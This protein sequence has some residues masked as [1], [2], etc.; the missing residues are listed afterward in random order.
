MG[1]TTMEEMLRRVEGNGRER[2][3]ATAECMWELATQRWTEAE[4]ILN[5]QKLWPHG[6]PKGQA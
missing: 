1:A 2:G 5:T 4:E 6:Q 3:E